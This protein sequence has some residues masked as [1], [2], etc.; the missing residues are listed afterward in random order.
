[1]K[2]SWCSLVCPDKCGNSISISPDCILSNPFQFIIQQSSYHWCHI[3]LILTA[4]LSNKINKY[5]VSRSPQLGFGFLGGVRLSPL[6]TAATNWP[7]VPAPD[8]RWSWMG[9]SRW[10]E[11]WQGKSMYSEKTCPSTTL[12][13]TNPTW[14]DLGSNPSRRGGKP[15]TNHLSYGTA[16][17]QLTWGSVLR[18]LC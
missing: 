16:P 8:D 4:S 13:T 10:N 14:P 12:S 9:S 18:V 1:V 17:R 6:G 11:N 15:A 7:I 2:L 3:V 5:A